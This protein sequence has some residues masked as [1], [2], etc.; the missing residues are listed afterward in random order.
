MVTKA[1][2]RKAA[3]TYSSM[4]ILGESGT[5]KGL[6]AHQYIW[7]AIDYTHFL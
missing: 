2:T 3:Q 5:V 6:F 1:I 7:L 4:L